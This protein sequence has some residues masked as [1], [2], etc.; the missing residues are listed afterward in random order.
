V[1]VATRLPLGLAAAG[2][3]RD[4]AIVLA[5]RPVTDVLTGRAF[6]GGELPLVEL[7][8]RYPVALLVPSLVLVEPA[9]VV[10][11]GATPPVPG[12]SENRAAV[13]VGSQTSPQET[14]PE[15]FNR[16]NHREDDDTEAIEPLEGLA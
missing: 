1:T 5:G 10:E 15:D 9:S 16:L 14:P 2:G 13:P 7:L 12:D 8:D 4:T 3:W 6:A 11:P